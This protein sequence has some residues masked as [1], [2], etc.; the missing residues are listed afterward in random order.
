LHL[1]T[2]GI[3]TK[4][5]FAATQQNRPFAGVLLTRSVKASNDCRNDSA[6]P[7]LLSA[8]I[9]PTAFLADRDR[10]AALYT[11]RI[12]KGEQPADLPVQQMSKFELVINLKAAKAFGLS[13]PNSILLLADLVIE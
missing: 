4:G 7:T 6:R 2:V 5:E 8:A 13:V 1:L 12:L 3:G 10:E 9:L 11:G